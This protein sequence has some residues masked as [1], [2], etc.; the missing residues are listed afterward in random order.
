MD[1]RRMDELL[2]HTIALTVEY[3][4]IWVCPNGSGKVQGVASSVFL[5]PGR[6]PLADWQGQ[7]RD[8]QG[9][10]ETGYTGA[11]GIYVLPRWLAWT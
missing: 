3:L 7:Q 10:R 11:I 6:T 8:V 4:W 9:R 2:R 1:P 5:R